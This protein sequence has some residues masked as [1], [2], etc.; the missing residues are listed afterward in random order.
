MSLWVTVRRPW[1]VLSGV[2]AYLVGLLI[3]REQ[4]VYVPSI[5]VLGGAGMKLMN[6]LPLIVCLAVLYCLER[7][8]SAAELTGVRPVELAD[9]ALVLVVGVMVLLAGAVLNALQNM[10][11]AIAAGRNVLFLTGLALVVRARFGG[12]VAASAAAG[13]LFLTTMAGLR[14]PEDPYPWAILLEPPAHPLA[15]FVTAAV[16]MAGLASLG[17]ERPSPAAR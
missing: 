6:F 13:W 17:R 2:V 16:L 10:P 15:A 12:V 7:R 4:V 8:L 5:S 1:I 9:R 11:T 3:V 14:S